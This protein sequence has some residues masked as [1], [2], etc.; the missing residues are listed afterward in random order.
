MVR[1]NE[2]SIK[3]LQLTDLLHVLQ[4]TLADIRPDNSIKKEK[5]CDD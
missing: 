4:I 1:Y 2:H 3:F 5:K